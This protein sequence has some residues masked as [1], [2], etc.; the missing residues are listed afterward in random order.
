MMPARYYPVWPAY[1]EAADPATLTFT[2]SLGAEP[3]LGGDAGAGSRRAYVTQERLVRVHQAQFRQRVLD[4]Y[5]C[6]CA[7]CRL[8]HA[9]L[10]DAAHILPEG[11][12]QGDPVVPNGLGLCKIH[13]A[14]FDRNIIGIR[15]DLVVEVRPDILEEHDG[16]MLRHGLQGFD[17]QAVT[18]PRRPADRPR[19]EIPR[20]ALPAVPPRRLTC[21]PAAP[22]PRRPAGLPARAGSAAHLAGRLRRRAAQRPDRSDAGHV[23][24]RLVEGLA[25]HR[26]VELGVPKLNNPPSEATS[27]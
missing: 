3:A 22:P 1:V 18:V 8:R 15:P 5:R 4:A 19:P 7:V 21:R 13:H 17:G 9:E 25:A 2:I 27:Q 11:H 12:P 23:H 10:L 14:A 24:D 26:A 6:T 20:R 16:P